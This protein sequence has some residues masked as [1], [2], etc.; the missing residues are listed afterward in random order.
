M[1]VSA[2]FSI[3]KDMGVFGVV[4]WFVKKLVDEIIS[5][6]KNKKEREE[7]TYIKLEETDKR[8]SKKINQNHDIVSSA[9]KSLLHHEL[10]KNCNIYIQRGSISTAE[11]DDLGYLFDSYKAVGGNGTGELIYR[12]A[13]NLPLKN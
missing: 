10:Y 2:W 6:Y 8:L 4:T 11:R 7:K 12:Q 9:L 13:M 3:L 5:Y 1:T